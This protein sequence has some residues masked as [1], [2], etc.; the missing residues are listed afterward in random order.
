MALKLSELQALELHRLY[1]S[2]N[3]LQTQFTPTDHT[4]TMNSFCHAAPYVDVQVADLFGQPQ[5][6]Q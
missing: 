4:V 5:R 6:E 1:S 3:G 2:P